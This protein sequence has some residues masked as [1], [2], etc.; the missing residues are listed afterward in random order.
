MDNPTRQTTRACL[1]SAVTSLEE[2]PLLRGWRAC[3]LVLLSGLAGF[4][5]FVLTP[6]AGFWSE[7][8][9]YVLIGGL[10]GGLANW[11]S[12]R[13]LQHLPGRWHSSS[14]VAPEPPEVAMEVE[15]HLPVSGST[16]IDPA[17]QVS[18]WL[19]KKENASDLAAMLIDRLP[20]IKSVMNDVVFREQITLT[21]GDKVQ[22]I[23]WAPLL[24]R[25]WSIVNT[26]P[27][28]NRLLARTTDGIVDYLFANRK[29]IENTVEREN[30]WWLPS[31]ADR[32]I[33]NAILTALEQYFADLNSPASQSRSAFLAAVERMAVD[34][35]SAQETA[36]QSSAMIERLAADP[37]IQAELN[38]VWQ[39]FSD[40]L[41]LAADRNG[42]RPGL[43]DQLASLIVSFG[44]ILA[45]H[46]GLHR[47]LNELIVRTEQAPRR[48]EAAGPPP[49]AVQEEAAAN[50]RHSG[51]FDSW[52]VRRSDIAGA[53]VGALV[54]CCA[55]LLSLL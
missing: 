41:V 31:A 14:E 47:L 49:A 23:T 29:W 51:H 6:A 30:V 19:V 36:A 1:E 4:C 3:V 39:Q 18:A 35:V 12:A 33:T 55:F 7:L 28:F 37:M 10:A 5:V 11:C 9:H 8:S 50:G 13:V 42:P 17:Q 26:S 22:G 21:L 43:A 52:T 20:V 24:R 32:R 16:A 15:D 46:D 44:H 25:S 54:G 45:T 27:E 48:D 40:E 38:S 2:P 53:F 34:F